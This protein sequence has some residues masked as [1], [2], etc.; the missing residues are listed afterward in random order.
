MAQSRLCLI[1][2]CGNQVKSLGLCNKH[3][4]NS[5]HLGVRIRTEKGKYKTCTILDCT[6]P[7]EARG[8]CVKHYNDFLATVG[9]GKTCI[10]ESCDKPAIANGMC[11]THH[12]RVQRNGDLVKYNQELTVY[13]ELTLCSV[14]DFCILWPFYSVPYPRITRNGRTYRANRFVCQHAHGD[15]PFAEA[16]AAHNCGNK[17]C[18]NPRHL[19]WDTPRN[20]T[21]DKYAH[22]TMVNGEMHH[23]CKLTESDVM[24]IRAMPNPNKTKIAADYGM[25]RSTIHAI[26]SRKIWKHI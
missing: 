5:R 8:M 24:A 18:V 23:R 19:R 17:L 25:A 15:P 13:V 4:Q 3:Y 22:G 16:Q 20:N 2:D 21:L 7:H 26:L 1:P 14:T 11:A 12:S 6:R 10:A 9:T